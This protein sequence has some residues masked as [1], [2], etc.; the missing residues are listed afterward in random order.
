MN[1]VANRQQTAGER[2]RV[3]RPELFGGMALLYLTE[4]SGRL[5]SPDSRVD[6]VGLFM[7]S[8]CG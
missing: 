3:N 5:C 7:S 8:A 1:A 6:N 2:K 4:L